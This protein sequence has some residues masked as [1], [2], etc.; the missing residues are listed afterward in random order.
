MAHIVGP[1]VGRLPFCPSQEI[2]PVRVEYLLRRVICGA[3]HF[4]DRINKSG[5][6]RIIEGLMF[7][8]ILKKTLLTLNTSGFEDLVSKR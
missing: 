7:H 3:T 8:N 2:P 5:E 1:I 6:E 4:T